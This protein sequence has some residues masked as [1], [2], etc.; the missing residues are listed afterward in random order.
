LTIFIKKRQFVLPGE[1][2]AED[3]YGI[4]VNVYKDEGKIFSSRVGLAEFDD[5][6]IN[7]VPLKGCYLPSVGD[8]VIG[9]VTD[10]GLSG[11]LLDIDAPYP[12]MLP[13]TEAITRRPTQTK[14]DL[15]KIINIGDLIIA[16]VIAFDRTRDPLLSIKGPGLG[17]ITSGKVVNISP[18][19]IPRLIGRKAS[20]VSMIK[21]ETGC[22]L[23]I[24]QNGVVLIS[25]SSQPKERAALDAVYKIEKEAHTE[26]LTDRVKEAIRR[27]VKDVDIQ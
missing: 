21:R 6:N 20:M 24:G 4:G 27:M 16:K 18:T 26:G 1:L 12:A 5:R 10:I 25:G 2:L 8:Q 3:N 23:M 19:K 17:R 11:W 22:E 15:T 7:V 9:K 13:V 14:T